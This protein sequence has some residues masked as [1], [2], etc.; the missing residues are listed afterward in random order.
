MPSSIERPV[1]YTTEEIEIPQS[2]MY[3]INEKVKSETANYMSNHYS[4]LDENSLEYKQVYSQRE[5]YNR[6]LYTNQYKNNIKD[7]RHSLGVNNLNLRDD[8]KAM[9]EL[10]IRAKRDELDKAR[11]EA[12]RNTYVEDIDYGGEVSPNLDSL[13]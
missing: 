12:T 3:R 11:V 10:Q 5:R 8:E 6:D 2:E 9:K 1:T 7:I 4:H 13:Q